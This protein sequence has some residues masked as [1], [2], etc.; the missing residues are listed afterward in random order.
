MVIYL[1]STIK[2]NLYCQMCFTIL[3]KIIKTNNN[4]TIVHVSGIMLYHVLNALSNKS[5]FSLDLKTNNEEA[6]LIEMGNWGQ[7]QERHGP[8]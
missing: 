3:I 8:P 1:Y 6:T 4:T 2:Y 7:L 5:V